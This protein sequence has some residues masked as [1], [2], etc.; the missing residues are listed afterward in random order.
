LLQAIREI[1]YYDNRLF[2]LNKQEQAISRWQTISGT[3]LISLSD[4]LVAIEIDKA[5]MEIIRAQ[6][7][8]IMEAKQRF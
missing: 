8:P 1:V 2:K 4:D 7:P 6:A 3:L 5:P